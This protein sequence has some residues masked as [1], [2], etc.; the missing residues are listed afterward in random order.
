MKRQ[1]SPSSTSSQSS[2]WSDIEIISL[3]QAEPRPALD[4]VL[5]MRTVPDGSTAL[6]DGFVDS[7]EEQS[8]LRQKSGTTAASELPPAPCN[9]DSSLETLALYRK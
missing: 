6:V 3:D 5:G 9:A 7:Q 4:D 1:E 2:Y 8:L